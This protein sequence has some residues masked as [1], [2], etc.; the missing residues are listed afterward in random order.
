M[1]LRSGSIANARAATAAT[2]TSDPSEILC[3]RTQYG[4]EPETAAPD[5]CA[6][7]ENMKKPGSDR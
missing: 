1:W 2:P 5:G 6:N 3:A 4:P 7:E